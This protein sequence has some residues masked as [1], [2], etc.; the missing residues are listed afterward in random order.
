MSEK[1][2]AEKH[3]KEHNQKVLKGETGGRTM[4]EVPYG[5]DNFELYESYNIKKRFLDASTFS[6]SISKRNPAIIP[7]FIVFGSL[8]NGIL[9]AKSE[10]GEKQSDTDLILFDSQSDKV[11][12]IV[13]QRP[14]IHAQIEK[15]DIKNI[16]VDMVTKLKNLLAMDLDL[17]YEEVGQKFLPFAFKL[18]GI[19]FGDD[20][21]KMQ[22]SIISL[23]EQLNESDR[24]KLWKHL[25][26]AIRDIETGRVGYDFQKYGILGDPLS[27]KQF[28]E[29]W[30]KRKGWSQMFCKE[31]GISF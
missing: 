22:S 20:I 26:I 29:R 10:K 15:M 30:E 4:P 2:N 3:W 11:D 28:V 31:N 7:G 21:I 6:K 27:F 14:K 9:R 8:V 17:S 25:S 19:P 12:M 1:F 18:I 5:E 23:L 24:N 16:E 13:R